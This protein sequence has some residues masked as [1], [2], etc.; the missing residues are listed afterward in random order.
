MSY[1]A[2]LETEQAVS[3]LEELVRSLRKGVVYIRH[4][5][6]QIELTPGDAL[7][8]ELEASAKKGKQKVSLELSWRLIPPAS[9]EPG[10]LSIG[11]SDP[12]PMV[13]ADAMSSVAPNDDVDRSDD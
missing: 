8:I 6:D 10:G 1:K 11:A 13:E 4:G 3:Y 12:A 9:D 7:E 5:E 2:L